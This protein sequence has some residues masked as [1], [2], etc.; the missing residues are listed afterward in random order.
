M[1]T[2][3]ITE[4]NKPHP[5]SVNSLKVTQCNLTSH[6]LQNTSIPDA[7]HKLLPTKHVLQYTV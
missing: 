6:K 4:T 7:K 5:H 3:I 2:I 1:I